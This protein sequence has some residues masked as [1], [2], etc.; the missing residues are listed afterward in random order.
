[1]EHPFVADVC[2]SIYLIMSLFSILFYFCIVGVIA[3]IGKA[4]SS[5]KAAGDDRFQEGRRCDQPDESDEPDVPEPTVVSAL[6]PTSGLLIHTRSYL[7]GKINYPTSL[8][9]GN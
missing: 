6:N 2:K 9:V 4:E 8:I 7:N 1:M 3:A 5:V